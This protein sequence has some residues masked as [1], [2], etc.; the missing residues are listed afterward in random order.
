MGQKSISQMPSVQFYKDL[1]KAKTMIS[2][3]DS[4]LREKINISISLEDCEDYEYQFKVFDITTQPPKLL[5]TSDLVKADYNKMVVFQT[6]FIMEYFFEKDQQIL[7]TIFKDINGEG[8]TKIDFKSSVGSIVGSRNNTLI[9]KINDSNPEKIKITAIELKDNM[10]YLNID[11]QIQ[12]NIP[13]NWNEPKNY[14]YYIVSGKTQLY[15]SETVATNGKLNPARIPI[16]LLKPDFSITIYDCHQ[17]MVANCRTTLEDFT[18]QGGPYST[19]NVRL[20]K[21]RSLTLTNKSAIRKSYTFIDYLKNGVQLGL[22]IAIDFTG[23]NGSP[24]EQGSLHAIQPGMMNDYERAIMSCGN[25]VAYYD[26]DQMFPVFGFGAIL[27]GEVNANMCFPVNSMDNPEIYT[28]NGVLDEYHKKV[29]NVGFSGPTYFAPILRRT[30]D[31]IKASHDNLKYQIL[32]ILTDGIINDMNETID[33]LVEGA[34][35]P[36]SV[37]IIGIGNAN[38]DNMEILDADDN[39][40]ISSTGEKCIRDLVQFVPFSKFEHNQ[41]RLAEEVLEEIP[42]QILEYY[43]KNNMYPETL[44]Y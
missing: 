14:F 22:V 11:F 8:S 6:T 24:S 16:N 20:S 5:V 40:L 41:Q 9:K 25:I 37:I 1:T 21:N 43:T 15:K 29:M 3:P 38:F 30:I 26:Y 17:K 28:I 34:K 7:V 31:M 18:R 27:P 10:E 13:L 32:M 39:P 44:K 4:N 42:T 19:I 2:M 23:S 35:L 33:L 36:L 12:S